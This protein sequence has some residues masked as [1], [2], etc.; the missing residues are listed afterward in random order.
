M[1]SASPLEPKEC[2]EE[3]EEK[4]HPDK[5][6][7]RLQFPLL[8]RS[9]CLV[10]KLS[11]LS[12]QTPTDTPPPLPTT[13]LPDDYYEEA[14]PLD[15]GSSPQYFTTNMN[16]SVPAQ[17]HSSIITNRCIIE[18]FSSSTSVQLFCFPPTASRNSVEDAYYEDA[19]NNYPTTRINGPPK[20]SC[21][22]PP[23]TSV[24]NVPLQTGPE[25]VLL[26]T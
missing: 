26:H 9:V 22:S 19:E 6:V 13:P 8:R 10:L 18:G 17:T 7:S 11:K 1:L 5:S 12:P 23:L 15:P 21:E 16:S 2:K 24:Y 4:S 25:I 20:N 3:E 14:V